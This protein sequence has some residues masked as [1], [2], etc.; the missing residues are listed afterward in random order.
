MGTSSSTR[1]ER[2][3][4]GLPGNCWCLAA[5]LSG[6]NDAPLTT[7]VPP[8]ISSLLGVFMVSIPRVLQIGYTITLVVA[9]V[10]FALPTKSD[11][12]FRT[13]MPPAP[14]QVGLTRPGQGAIGQI[15]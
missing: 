6:S 5:C 13:T 1:K 12:Q 11:A 4:P 15:G 8:S 14:P 9:A 7:R 2:G 3:G 10:L